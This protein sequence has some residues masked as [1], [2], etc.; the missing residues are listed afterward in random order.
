MFDFK[1][2]KKRFAIWRKKLKK[3]VDYDTKI[4][5][6]F[7]VAVFFTIFWVVVTSMPTSVEL[8]KNIEIE[9]GAS[10][11]KIA[12]SLE[13][14]GFIYSSVVFSSLVILNNDP[15][16]SGEYRFENRENI[17]KIIKRLTKGDYG[18]P[19]KTIRIPEGAT[20]EEMGI[21]FEDNFRNFDREAFYQLT[22]K[23]EGYLFPDTYVFLENIKTHEVVDVLKKTF[24]QKIEELKK[25]LGELTIPLEEIIIMA[26]I[27]EKEADD[28][29]REQTADILWHRIEIDMPLQVD[30]TFVYSRGKG[31]FDLTKEDLQEEEN[32]FNTYIHKG[33]PP[34]PISNPGYDSLKAAAT[35]EPTEFLYFLTGLN[36]K[37]YYAK[38]F[39]EHKR[40]KNNY[41]R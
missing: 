11:K 16:I 20:L 24:E 40:N 29:N 36:G 22:E 10:I 2:I 28:E 39:E 34:T 21:I 30:A 41:L 25:E 3:S 23:Q 31:T 33:L 1:L 38:T 7:F 12:R 14:D 13:S 27:V 9:K 18:I 17:F 19:S 15:I 32:P 5:F 35:P 26:S 4:I 37:T 6:Y 8:P